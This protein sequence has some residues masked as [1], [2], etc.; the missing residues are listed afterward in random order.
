MIPATSMTAFSSGGI[1]LKHK[2]PLRTTLTRIAALYRS[3]IQRVSKNSFEG[4]LAQWSQSRPPLSFVLKASG[5]RCRQ[6]QA[7]LRCTAATPRDRVVDALLRGRPEH[8]L[9][10]RAFQ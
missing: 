6:P 3:A 4:S 7:V 1:D 5:R 10:L 8:L 2:A 9:Q